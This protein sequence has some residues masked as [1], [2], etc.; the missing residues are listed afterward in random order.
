MISS[1]R[2]RPLDSFPP[3]RVSRLDLPFRSRVVLSCPPVQCRFPHSS[4]FVHTVGSRRVL[5]PKVVFS[6]E[7]KRTFQTTVYGHVRLA[8]EN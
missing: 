5:S 3:C 8:G 7:M 1:T 6:T 2:R 4:F